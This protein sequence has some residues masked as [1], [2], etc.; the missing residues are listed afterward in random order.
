MPIVRNA[1]GADL[2][3][4]PVDGEDAMFPIHNATVAAFGWKGSLS[5]WFNSLI[6]EIST[7]QRAIW[8]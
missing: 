3:A 5:P 6:L 2:S 8:G 1:R 7:G 4:A